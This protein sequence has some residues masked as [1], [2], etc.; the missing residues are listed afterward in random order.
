LTTTN[1]WHALLNDNS[2]LA[3]Q[4]FFRHATAQRNSS[5]PF[6]IR[7]TFRAL[8]DH[9]FDETTNVSKWIDRMWEIDRGDI[10]FLQSENEMLRHFF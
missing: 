5:Y 8:A 2:P 6:V 3:F 4:I 1:E 10:V 9:I 7:E